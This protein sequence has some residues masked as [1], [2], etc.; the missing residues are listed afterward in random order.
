MQQDIDIFFAEIIDRLEKIANNNFRN[1]A[2]YEAALMVAHKMLRKRLNTQ[3]EILQH[4]HDIGEL[5]NELGNPI[6]HF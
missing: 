3:I 4:Y 5:Q 1:Y 2:N 6:T